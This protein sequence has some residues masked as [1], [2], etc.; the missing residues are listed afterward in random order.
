[1]GLRDSAGAIALCLTAA[2][3][4]RAESPTTVDLNDPDRQQALQLYRQ[5]K[6]PDAA[7]LLEKVVAKYP[8]DVDAHEAL[9]V[10]LV[11]RATGESDDAK[12]KADRLSARRELLRAKELG[13]TS[14]L[15]QALL[16]EIPEDGAGPTRST[17]PGVAAALTEG[18]AAFA[19]ADWPQAIAAYLRAWQLDSSRPEAALYLGDTYFRLKD[20]DQAGEWFAKAIQADPNQ[21]TA[22]R[23]WGDALLSQ[24]KMKEA[25]AKYIEGVVADPYRTGSLAGLRSWLSK[26]N[27]KS[28]E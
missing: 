20:M 8:A 21:E 15:C 14:D 16:S 11:S 24:N 25:R 9:G 19:R 5:H 10:A 1:M 28:K 23:Y 12:A 13:D 4:I 6:M 2:T 26:N 7:A 22:Y 17:R 27:L 3:T 18:E